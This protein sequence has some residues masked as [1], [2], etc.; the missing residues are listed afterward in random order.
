MALL[1][2]DARMFAGQRVACLR[3]IKLRR[4]LPIIEAVAASAVLAQ[5]ALMTVNVAGKAVARQSQKRSVQI[6]DLNSR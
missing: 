2:R 1:A 3:M 5:L 4:W 6:L